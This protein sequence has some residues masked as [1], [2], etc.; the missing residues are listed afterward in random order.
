MRSRLPLPLQLYRSGLAALEPAAA[1]FLL[2]RTR[3]GKEDPARLPERRGLPGRERP[4]GRLA[5]VHGAS[6]GEI[7]PLVLIV[8]RLTRRGFYVLVASGTRTSAELI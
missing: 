3:R 4:D 6:S 1:S 7:L 8:E 5:W 2:W